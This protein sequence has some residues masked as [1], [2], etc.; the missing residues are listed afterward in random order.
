MTEGINMLSIFSLAKSKSCNNNLVENTGL[1][2]KK[3]SFE[4]S[5]IGTS[6]CGS[7]EE[8]KKMKLEDEPLKSS[9]EILEEKEE[10]SKSLLL[11]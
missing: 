9:V 11:N 7:K 5:I 6:E 4:D 10:A 8:K 3:R 2:G 1:T